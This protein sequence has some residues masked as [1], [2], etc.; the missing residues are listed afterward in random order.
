MHI[1]LK[2][3]RE[4]EM[5]KDFTYWTQ[6]CHEELVEMA[7]D[8]SED[9]SN[10]AHVGGDGIIWDNVGADIYLALA[11]RKIKTDPVVVDDALKEAAAIMNG[12]I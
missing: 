5:N 6:D 2:K 7:L 3:N 4:K 12:G 1:A 9:S 8:F 10:R 11:K